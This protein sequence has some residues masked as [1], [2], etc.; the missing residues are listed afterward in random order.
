[1]R[2]MYIQWNLS[3]KPFELRTNLH[4]MNKNFGPNWCHTQHASQWTIQGI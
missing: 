3:H 1:M 2:S 4:N